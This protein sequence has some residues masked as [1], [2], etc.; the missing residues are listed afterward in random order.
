MSRENVDLVRR[1]YAL[2]AD[3]S[4]LRRGDYDVYLE[5]IAPDA[6]LVPPAVYPD[7]QS[8]YIGPED[9]RH[10]MDQ[11]DDVFDDWGFEPEDFVDAGDRVVVLVR[12]SGTS[13]D[14]GVPVTIHAAHVHTVRDG[15]IRRFEVFLD[16]EE[17][18]EAAGLR[19]R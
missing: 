9:W 2:M 13:K 15:L 3:L 11:I 18:L 6:E 19:G 8:S 16:R 12:T 1:A 14:S 7:V 17:A 5:V 10:W 4:P